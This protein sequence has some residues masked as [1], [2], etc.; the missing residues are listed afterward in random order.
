MVITFHITHYVL[1]YLSISQILVTAFAIHVLGES[2]NDILRRFIVFDHTTNNKGGFLHLLQ[3]QTKEAYK[4]D[5]DHIAWS[6]KT[7]RNTNTMMLLP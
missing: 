3:N 1:T 5:R 4:I 7:H 6:K 2:F